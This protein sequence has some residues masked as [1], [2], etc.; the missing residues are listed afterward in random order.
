M[1]TAILYSQ[2]NPN[3]EA[4]VLAWGLEAKS[5]TVREGLFKLEWFK[6]FLDPNVL[7]DGRLGATARLP[8][9]PYGKEPI[10]VISDFLSCLWNYAKARITEEIGSVADLGQSRRG[11]CYTMGWGL[12]L[13]SLTTC[14]VGR[15][16]PHWSATSRAETIRLPG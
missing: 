15:C 1:P 9:L 2:P 6:L 8:D 14:R 7:R 3:E 13:T 11:L 12:G 16:A 10:D 5:A 4:K